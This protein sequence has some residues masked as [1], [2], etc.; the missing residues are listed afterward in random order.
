M[1]PHI[2]SVLFEE[3]IFLAIFRLQ[4]RSMYESG[5][6]SDFIPDGLICLMIIRVYLIDI[7]PRRAFLFLLS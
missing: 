6:E 2:V 1:V 5:F 3:E 4:A 7:I